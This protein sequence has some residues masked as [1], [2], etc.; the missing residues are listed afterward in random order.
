MRILLAISCLCLAACST[1]PPIAEPA[2]AGR[3]QN[4]CVP[5]AAEMT[6]GLHKAGIQAKVLLITTPAWKHA[7]CVYLYP[8]G[9]NRLWVWDSEWKSIQVRAFFSD[10]DQ[11]ARAWI[12]AVNQSQPVTSAEF[13]Q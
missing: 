3:L 8:S 9:E 7:V 2:F 4:A 1:R 13:L 10:P 5:E 6:E 12:A 11:V